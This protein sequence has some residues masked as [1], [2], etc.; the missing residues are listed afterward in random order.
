MIGYAY[1]L[2]IVLVTRLNFAIHTDF[3]QP[4]T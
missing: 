3:V 1:Y 2:S 4:V